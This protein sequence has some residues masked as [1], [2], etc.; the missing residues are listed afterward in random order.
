[1]SRFVKIVYTV[2]A[3]VVVLVPCFDKV[4]TFLGGTMEKDHRRERG[5][6]R[7]IWN[8]CHETKIE[9]LKQVMLL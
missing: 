5:G 6:E 4:K 8:H 3:S 2:I 1:M 7:G 9:I